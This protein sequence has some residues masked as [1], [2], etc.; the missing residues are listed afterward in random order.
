MKQELAL[1]KGKVIEVTIG[2]RAKTAKAIVVVL[3]GSFTSPRFI[4]RTEIALADKSFPETFQPYH[5]VLDLPWEKAITAVRKI[6]KRNEAIA[7]K[8]LSLLIDEIEAEGFKV[9]RTG[10]VGAGKRNLERIGSPHIRA[11]AAEGVLF[12]ELLEIASTSC[13]LKHTS[14]DEKKLNEL[15]EGQLGP[16]SVVNEQVSKLGR[17]A[18]RPWRADEKAAAISALLV[19]AT[20][21]RN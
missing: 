5:E 4:R 16:I 15:A 8:S 19:L 11:H 3:A 6:I 2:L 18:G 20:R 14:F 1:T 7:S 13:G 12:R 17:I 9:R 10:I 21:G